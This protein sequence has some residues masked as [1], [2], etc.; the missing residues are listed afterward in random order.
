M[1]R[2]LAV[3]SESYFEA[4]WLEMMAKRGVQ[5]TVNSYSTIIDKLAKVVELAE[6]LRSEA[7]D[8]DAAENW[9]DRMAEVDV[10]KSLKGFPP[11]M[12]VFK[13]PGDGRLGWKLMR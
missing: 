11:E 7:G 13:P 8:I 3:A 9:L 2:G 5:P 4:Y 12:H 10:L 1:R 6:R